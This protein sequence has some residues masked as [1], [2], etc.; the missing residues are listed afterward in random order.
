MLISRRKP[1][2]K[3][4]ISYQP[5]N[6]CSPSGGWPGSW[7]THPLFCLLPH[8]HEPWSMMHKSLP[9]FFLTR[10]NMCFFAFRPSCCFWI[11]RPCDF[12]ERLRHWVGLSGAASDLFSILSLC[13]PF[14]YFYYLLSFAW[15][16]VTLNPPPPLHYGVPQGSVLG[17]YLFS[18]YILTLCQI[19][20][21]Y[22]SLYLYADN[23]RTNF[24]FDYNL[25]LLNAFFR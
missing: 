18:I 19:L 12:I 21:Q 5:T 1:L 11:S 20:H 24:F 16:L 23:C 6:W 8:F 9:Q 15:P 4:E 17:P 2:K 10:P 22:I 13:Y 14:Y 25:K 7:S 3:K